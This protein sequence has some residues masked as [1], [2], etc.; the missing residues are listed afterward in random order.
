MLELSRISNLFSKESTIKCQKCGYKIS[1][2][3]PKD[4][5]C[6][7]CGTFIPAIFQIN[8]LE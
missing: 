2:P 4:N 1:R 8:E 5:L 7:K 6:P 3:Y